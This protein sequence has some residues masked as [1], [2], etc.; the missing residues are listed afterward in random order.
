MTGTKRI[1]DLITKP[2][3]LLQ[4]R[5]NIIDAPVSAGKTYFALTVLPTWSSPEKILYLIDT[6]NGE[7]HIQNN[8]IAIGRMEYALCD[9]ATGELWGEKE[10]VKGKLPVMTYAGFGAEILKKPKDGAKFDWHK[11]DFIICDEMQNLVDYQRFN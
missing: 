1:S 11:F 4:G 5:I 2:D 10:V 9:Y 8:I 3:A 6:T 7:M